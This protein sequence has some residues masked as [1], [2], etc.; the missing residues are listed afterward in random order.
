M[1]VV[2]VTHS[3]FLI[4]KNKS[5]RIRVLQKEGQEEGTRIV[6]RASHNHYEPIRSA[7]GT[8]VAETTFIG[9]C[10]L[11]VEGISDQ[12]LIAGI[13]DYLRKTGAS[14]T[15]VLDLNTITI[16]P[17]SGAGSIPYLVYVAAGR[18][19]E[20]ISVVTLMDSDQSGKDAKVELLEGGPQGKGKLDKDFIVMVGDLIS[21]CNTQGV[22]SGNAESE[23]EDLIPLRV[24]ALA[25]KRYAFEI[26]GTSKSDLDKL[27]IT[28]I[29]DDSSKD[30]YM[31]LKEWFRNKEVPIKKFDKIPLMLHVVKLLQVDKSIEDAERMTIQAD[32]DI[33]ASNWKNIF[34]KLNT[35]IRNAEAERLNDTRGAT[36]RRLYRKFV[37][38]YPEKC[39]KEEAAL[40]LEE[41]LRHADPK[42]DLKQMELA[43]ALL[44]QEFHLKTDPLTD[45]GSLPKFKDKLGIILGA[46]P[47]IVSTGAEALPIIESVEN[48]IQEVVSS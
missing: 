3:P 16:V 27:E 17:T 13:S 10:N 20:K 22:R 44:S 9:G 42:N 35:S 34:S 28:A 46:E 45:L 4:D 21:L 11:M 24:L 33:M 30:I 19:Q 15:E 2:Y 12:V 29:E 1:Q 18:D 38:H 32:I 41:I 8:F 48:P 47:I 39:T 5:H 14:G 7:L 26:V 25:S 31:V 43:F 6:E 40:H 37:K 23:I 36:Y